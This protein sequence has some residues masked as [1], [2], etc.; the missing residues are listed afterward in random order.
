MGA[1]RIFVIK[2]N[3]SW[4][5]IVG[6]ALFSV[7]LI[8]TF[9]IH[10]I[11]FHPTKRIWKRLWKWLWKYSDLKPFCSSDGILL[12]VESGYWKELSYRT[13]DLIE[14]LSKISL[15]D[16]IINC[17]IVVNDII[18]ILDNIIFVEK[19]IVNKNYAMAQIDKIRK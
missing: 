6:F 16:S 8:F 1:S 2:L 9:T 19:A 18:D 4:I 11:L 13:D 15:F 14:N 5:E 17:K 7:P 3:I 12:E 10:W